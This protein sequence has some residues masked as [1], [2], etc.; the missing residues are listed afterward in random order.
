MVRTVGCM[1]VGM[2][3][4]WGCAMPPQ[5]QAERAVPERDLNAV[6]LARE[7]LSLYQRTRFAEAELK[8]RQALYLFPE[9]TNLRENLAAALEGTL[10]FDEAADIYSQLLQREP[11]SIRYRMA[12]ARVSA[13]AG[14]TER[15]RQL[16]GEGFDRAIERGDEGRAGD[17]ARSFASFLYQ[18]GREEDAR[19]FSEL[20]AHYRK[21]TQQQA[22]HARMLNASGYF[23][24]ALSFTALSSDPQAK[25]ERA[26]AFVG[27]GDLTAAMR[28]A[29][30]VLEADGA[31]P[32]ALAEARSLEALLARAQ[33]ES[34]AEG[35]EAA[36]EDLPTLSDETLVVWPPIMVAYYRKEQEKVSKE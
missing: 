19:C 27:V 35:D 24:K 22:A 29:Q 31:D 30:D 18:R 7:G 21:T 5:E 8:F 9:A 15:A 10:Q 12:L 25:L 28:D 3:A 20:A 23:L 11:E 34:L 33:R 2:L 6:S 16:Y 32:I 26:L 1:L 14:M 36:L 13:A 4:L 17:V